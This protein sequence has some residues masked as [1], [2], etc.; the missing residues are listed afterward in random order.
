[1]MNGVH[2]TFQMLKISGKEPLK[3]EKSETILIT[4]Q[5]CGYPGEWEPM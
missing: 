1:M 5:R 2:R 3:A 4:Y